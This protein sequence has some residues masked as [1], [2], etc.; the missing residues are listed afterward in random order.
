VAWDDDLD[1]PHLRIAASGA[2]RVG[3]LAGPGTGKTKY[4]LMRRVARLLTEGV[5]GDRV[6]LISFTRVAAAD[7]RDKVAELE[8]VGA[9]EVRATTLHAYCLRLLQRDSILALSGRNPRILLDHEK[10]LMLRDIGGGFGTI[11]D[12]RK[13]LEALLAGWARLATE[14]PGV[15]LEDEDRSFERKVIRWL[16]IHRAMLIGEVVPIARRYLSTNP[17]AEE[18]DAFDHL[19]IDEYQDLNALEQDLLEVLATNAESLCV[20]GD[21]D[22]SIYSVRYANPLGIRNFLARPDVETHDIAVCGRSPANVVYM[23]NSLIEQAPRRSKPPLEPLFPNR[24]GE[25]SIVQWPDDLSEV[26]GIASAIADDVYRRGIE[27]GDILVLTNWR[28]LGQRIR[29]RVIDLNIPVRSYFTE[30]ILDSDASR[31]ALALLRL[32]IDAADR[33]AMRVLVGLE[34]QSGRTSAYQRLLEYCYSHALEPSDVLSRLAAGRHLDGLRVPALV[35][36]FR[37]AMHRVERLRKLELSDLVD[38]LFPADDDT[39]A[40]LRGIALDSLGVA[41]KPGDVLDD[42]VLAVTQDDVPQHPNFVRIMSLH[43]SKGLTADT[44]YIVGAVDGILP[45]VTSTDPAEIQDAIAEGR[46]LFYVAITRA[47]KE[48]VIST[49][50]TMDRADAYARRVNFEPSTT[51]R[52]GDRVTIRT[53]ASPYIA[54]LGPSAPRG[55]RGSSWLASRSG[56]A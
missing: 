7:L 24:Q 28:R 51:R 38:E 37:L 1:G 4:G 56:G 19:V 33:P 9:E 26:D 20:A 13:L 5:P 30:E 40:E 41:E 34:E 25:V 23:A 47:V 31:E 49:S 2:A 22:Q 55:E 11:H 15:A 18:L 52:L 50:R 14:H 32:A 35:E 27:P 42:V 48:L 53:I 45:T 29:D 17:A 10:D 46:R 16:N 12:R 44:V 36:R 43:K 21:D 3:V 6:L 8:V 39:L 54:E